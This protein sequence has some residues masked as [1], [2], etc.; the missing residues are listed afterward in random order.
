MVTVTLYMEEFRLRSSHLLAF[1]LMAVTLRLPAADAHLQTH[2]HTLT[3]P[4]RTHR[5]SDM[6]Q[7]LHYQSADQHLRH[8]EGRGLFSFSEVAMATCRETNSHDFL[9]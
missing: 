7:Q 9:V 1:D 2:R 6:K 4:S 8:G 3:A 5:R